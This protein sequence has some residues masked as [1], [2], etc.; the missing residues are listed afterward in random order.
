[1]SGLC[2]ALRWSVACL[3]PARSGPAILLAVT[4]ALFSESLAPLRADP[5]GSAVL[6][7]IDGTLA[8]I[9]EHAADASVPETTRQLMI[10]VSR[11][12]GLLACISGRRASEARAMVS[13]GTIAYLGS[14]GAE[15]LRSGWTEA[16]LDPALAQWTPRVDEFRR[17]SDTPELR[18]RRVRIEDKGPIIAYHWRGAV[19]EQ[20]A[21]AAIDAIA[22]QA[23]ADGLEVFWGR[24][25]ME[26]RPP[27]RIDKG[28][29]VRSVLGDGNFSS[30]LYAGDDATDL[31]AFRALLELRQEGRIGHAVRV[32]VRSEDGPEAILQEADIV[33]SGTEGVRELLSALIAE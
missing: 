3:R 31:D 6:L 25:V 22:E 7:D 27:V 24:K 32:G 15:L 30:V 5:A 28:L 11:R 21:R 4:S 12:Y 29:G 23:Q 9:V 20:E 8:P 1:M 10:A 17:E 18:R 13:I 2:A 16:R 26:V 14:H 19:D 33:V